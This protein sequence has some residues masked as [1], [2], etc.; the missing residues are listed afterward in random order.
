MIK[1]TFVC[2]IAWSFSL[3]PAYANCVD[4]IRASALKGT[5]V[6]GATTIETEAK[7]F[8]SE[9][10][11]AKSKGKALSLSGSYGGIGLGVGSSQTSVDQVASKYCDAS[12][13]YK[14]KDNNYSQYIETIAPGAFAAYEKCIS[15]DGSVV[16]D[17]ADAGIQ[18]FDITFMVSNKSGMA[19]LQQVAYT[20][21]TGFECFW[22][23][24][25]KET[26]GRQLSL[27]ANSS[28]T[29]QCRRKNQGTQGNI[30]IFAQSSTKGNYDFLWKSFS[31]GIAVDELQAIKN[32][33]LELNRTMN[34]AIVA[35]DGEACPT[36]WRSVEALAGRAIIGAG[37][38]VGLSD[39]KNGESGGEE[40]HILNIDEMPSHTHGYIFTDHQNTPKH[41]DNTEGEFGNSNITAQTTA[42]GTGQAHNNMQPFVAYQFCRKII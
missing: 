10:A 41:T 37:K 20:A 15:T 29:L 26:K 2:L 40:T 7:L 30:K 21:S 34:S 36:G 31:N 1:Q 12:N 42:A 17:L 6:E 28:T 24:G 38:G 14:Y 8:C 39:R 35:F 11:S 4:V 32:A 5:V 25:D 18:A 22:L 13:G 16:A 23:S 3:S 33:N 27:A 9:Y 19:A